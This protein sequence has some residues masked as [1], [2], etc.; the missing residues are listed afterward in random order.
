M[1]HPP[2]RTEA[3]LRHLVL[4]FLAGLL[5]L[6]GG[7]ASAQGTLT[8]R[9]RL[10]I[11]NSS[12]TAGLAETLARSFTERFEGVQPPQTGTLGS[13]RAMEAFCSGIGPQ[14]PDLL[15]VTRRLSRA[16]IET[17]VANGVRDII[18]VQLG[19]GAVVLA[20]RRGEA[21]PGLTS[22]QIYEALAAE[23]VVAE[24]FVPNPARLWSD[25][26]TGL[27]RNPIRMILPVAGSGHR[28]LFDDLVMEAGCR[29]V[30]D[31][32]LLFEAAFRRTKCITARTDGRV[33][34]VRADQAVAALLAAPAG[35]L[36]VVSYDQLLASGGNLV[37]VPLDGIAP[38]VGSIGSLDYEQARTFFL[39]AKRQH[40][41][42]QQGIGVVRGIH[43]F[44]V[45]STSEH[46]AGP[47]GYLLAAGLVPLVP[48]E[49][50]AQRRIAEQA[51]LMSR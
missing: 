31:I 27:P 8:L 12:S 43:E 50:A 1:T 37:A 14:T 49:R 5:V 33:V 36:A 21:M 51:R 22:R 4:G 46:A 13:V 23:R 29:Y 15:L 20:A 2:S 34:D 28:A 32:R 24:E 38:S 6:G 3:A 7:S 47:G 16:V 19:L 9:D 18:E 35:T 10:V 40:S 30:P 39:Y 42:N 44:L 25:V 11:V 45:E 17:C 26:G 41:R 48:A